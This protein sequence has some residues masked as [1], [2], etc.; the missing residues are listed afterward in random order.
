MIEY[1][2]VSYAPNFGLALCSLNCA[3]TGSI[4]LFSFYIISY[5]SKLSFSCELRSSP[6]HKMRYLQELELQWE[7]M[8]SIFF[9]LKIQPTKCQQQQGFSCTFRTAF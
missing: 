8:A 2:T 3:V 9:L 6:S 5:H 4:Y 1:H 7:K